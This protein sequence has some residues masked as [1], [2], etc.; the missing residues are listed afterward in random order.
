M[1]KLP[2]YPAKGIISLC[3]EIQ[4]QQQHQTTTTQV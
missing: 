4:Q 2:S 1:S 3:E